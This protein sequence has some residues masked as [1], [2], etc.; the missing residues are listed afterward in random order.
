MM[1]HTS[2]SPAV[3][4]PAKQGRIQLY[5]RLKNLCM[6]QLEHDK[7]ERAKLVMITYYHPS[8]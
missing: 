2:K 8:C 5:M 6:A 4:N 7:M 3:P 1:I